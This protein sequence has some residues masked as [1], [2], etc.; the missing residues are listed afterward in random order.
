MFY[1][2]TNLTT[3]ILNSPTV[4]KLTNVNA[5]NNSGIK[6]GICTIYV[7]DDLVET[8]QAD[9]YWGPYANQIKPISEYV[10]E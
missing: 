1:N 4:F 5:V 10:E 2:C 3:L 6:T 9:T 8:Y 7:P